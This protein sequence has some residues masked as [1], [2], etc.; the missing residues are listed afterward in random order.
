MGPKGNQGERGQTGDP[1]SKGS[2]V[3][4]GTAGPM[5]PKGNQGE[6]GQ[7]GHPGSRGSDGAPGT[8]GPMGHKG[9]QGERGQTGDP[10]SKGSNGSPGTAGPEGPKGNQGERGEKGLP[11]IPGLPGINGDTGTKEEKAHPDTTASSKVS[12]LEKKIDVL[13][14]QLSSLYKVLHFISG[15]K[16]TGDKFYAAKGNEG[17][18]AAAQ[19]FCEGEGGTL[20]TPM[21]QKE[22]LI[23]HQFVKAKGR[24]IFLGFNDKTQ[25]GVFTYLNG[26]KMTYSNW[27]PNEPNGNTRENCGEFYGSGWNDQSCNTKNIIVCE[28]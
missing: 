17:D 24:N 4:P 18:Y 14:K 23:I 13:E 19:A 27:N 8:A 20:P 21:N 5:G 6:R 11:G 28:F 1:G 25:E 15:V 3:A 22:D 10:G 7:P 12:I 2:D 16:T 9:N 26:K